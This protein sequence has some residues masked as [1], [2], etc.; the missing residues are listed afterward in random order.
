NGVASGWSLEATAGV[1]FHP[2]VWLMGIP[3]A[4]AGL[5]GELM[6]LKTILNEFVAYLALSQ[7]MGDAALSQRSFII[8]T[9][10]LCGFANFASI[11]IQ[12][13]GIGPLA[14]KRQGDLARLGLKAMLGGT[15]AAFMTACIAGILL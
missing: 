2:L 7:H 9:Y 13:G 3:W 11:G 4:E 10:A 14:P 12:I 8:A 5:V 15:L 1:F 6:G